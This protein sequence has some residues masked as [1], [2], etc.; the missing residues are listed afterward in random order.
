MEFVGALT[1][2]KHLDTWV[3]TEHE[4]KMECVVG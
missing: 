1:K 3:Q 4:V 2:V